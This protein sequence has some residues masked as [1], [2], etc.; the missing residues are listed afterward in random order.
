MLDCRTRGV[1]PQQHSTVLVPFSSTSNGSVL[2]D[3]PALAWVL[4][5]LLFISDVEL[6]GTPRL[7]VVRKNNKFW[8]L[9]KSSILSRLRVPRELSTLPDDLILDA[10]APWLGSS[11]DVDCMSAFIFRVLLKA[12]A[13]CNLLYLL[14][15]FAP[16]NPASTPTAPDAAEAAA[17]AV[18]LWSAARMP[19]SLFFLVLPP[20]SSSSP[21]SPSP[22]R[23]WLSMSLSSPA[24][25]SICKPKSYSISPMSTETTQNNQ[26]IAATRPSGV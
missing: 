14:P 8:L 6:A 4:V 12:C 22:T 10:V 9:L 11:A 19:S 25:S 16:T 21:S 7:V 15:A 13:L 1:S 17:A 18:F 3:C 23:S 20:S 2:Q 26:G 5:R 24:S